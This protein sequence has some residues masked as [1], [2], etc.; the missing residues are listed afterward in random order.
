MSNETLSSKF[1]STIRETRQWLEDCQE[2]PSIPRAEEEELQSLLAFAKAEKSK[3]AEHQRR[4]QSLKFQASKVKPKISA[5]PSETASEADE[6]AELLSSLRQ[7]LQDSCSVGTLT[8]LLEVL[9]D[10]SSLPEAQQKNLATIQEVARE[11]LAQLKE[12]EE[13]AA[14]HHA[15]E[16]ELRELQKQKEELLGK[17]KEARW[18][19]ERAKNAQ[20]GSDSVTSRDTSAGAVE[21]H[22]NP[23]SRSNSDVGLRPE[24]PPE[25]TGPEVEKAPERP[26]SP[27]KG[28]GKGVAPKAPPKAKAK[29]KTHHSAVSNG[30]VTLH[31]HVIK[32]EEKL[33]SKDV[34]LSRLEALKMA[35]DG[36]TLESLAPQ[37]GIFSSSQ[38]VEVPMSLMEHYWKKR[39]SFAPRRHS[40][41]ALGTIDSARQSLLDE[42]KLQMLGISLKH[43]EHRNQGVKGA[44]AIVSIK[45][46]ILRCDF[47]VLHIECLSVIRTVIKQHENDGQP[48][49]TFVTQ[50]GEDSIHSLRCPIEHRLVYELCKVPQ[51][52]DRLECMLFHQTC[53]DNLGNCQRDLDT[54]Y[55][56]LEM[57]SRKRQTIQRFFLTALR[58]GQSL[59]R[60]SKRASQAPNGFELASLEKLAETKST[61]LPRMSV[62]HFVL[63]LLSPEEVESLFTREDFTEL[64]EAAI[65]KTHKVYSD[66]IEVAQGMYSVQNICQTGTYVRPSGEA[67]AIHRRRR[68]LPARSNTKD[69]GDVD[70]DDLFFEVMTEFV[71]ENLQAA[72]DLSERAFNLILLYKEL[73]IYFDDLRSVYPPPKNENDTR[74]D[75]VEVFQRFAAQIQLHREQVESEKLR[76][77]LEAGGTLSTA[78]PPGTPRNTPRYGTPRRNV[79]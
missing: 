58:L 18:T 5:P 69:E 44:E 56:A 2:L 47:D 15:Q 11:R 52:V 28:K 35:G 7:K 19:A 33:E 22:S 16:A 54:H 72:E 21:E 71:N 42:K 64:Q 3:A 62:L 73:A 61:K 50:N 45:C 34:F 49:T 55:K 66:C 75:L 20:D 57:L 31:W 25:R 77:F 10:T 38:E 14:Q 26:A 46:A 8:G 59:N 29:A 37:P 1:A 65:R 76:E 79:R 27:A 48:V 13:A 60:S 30:F 43:H 4:L 39:D 74:K 51:I 23:S 9:K 68:T 12:A 53:R 67:I 41:D 63:A 6:P 24:A 36:D 70:D 40:V 78:T 17:V 32:E